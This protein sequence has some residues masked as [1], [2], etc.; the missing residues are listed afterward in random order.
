MDIEYQD[1]RLRGDHAEYNDSTH[2]ARIAGH[3]QFDFETEHLEASDGSYNMITGAGTFHNVL[4][5]FTVQRRP[6]TNLLIS[7]NPISFTARV[8][9]RVDDETYTLQDALILSLIHI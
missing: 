6:A 8:I 7:Q 2:T 4:G 3:V 1:K 5:T 9:H